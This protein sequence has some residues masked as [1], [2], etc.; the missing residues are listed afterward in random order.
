[1]QLS[2]TAIH[3]RVLTQAIQS[4]LIFTYF[5]YTGILRTLETHGGG[6][7]CAGLVAFK[8]PAQH[9][10]FSTKHSPSTRTKCVVCTR[11]I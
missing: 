3:C 9:D 5:K 8:Y 11:C 2:A 7:N 1:M 10:K 4:T 6:K